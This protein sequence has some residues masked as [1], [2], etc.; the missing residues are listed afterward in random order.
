MHESLPTLDNS[1]REMDSEAGFGALETSKGPLPLKALNVKAHILGLVTRVLV[2]QT[3]VNT[4]R[5]A[6]EAVYIFPLPPRAAVSGFTMRVGDRLVEGMLFERGQAR[7]NYRRAIEAGKQAAMAEEDRPNVFTLSVGNLMPGDVAEICF[8]LSG[9]LS[10][11]GCEAEWRFPLVVAPRYIPGSPLEADPAGLGNSLDTDQ[12][13]DASRL[14]PPTLLP[15]YPNPVRLGI[16]IEFDP[17]GLAVSDIRSSLHAITERREGGRTLI[18]L[19][20]AE[21]VDRDFIL[22]C[23]LGSSQCQTTAVLVPDV[24]DSPSN[25]EYGIGTLMVTIVPPLPTQLERKGRDVVF[26]L[27]R[28][29]SMDGWKIVAARR[30]IARMV[31]TLGPDDRFEVITFS[32]VLDSLGKG[33]AGLLPATDL[34][35]FRALE[36]LAGT[37][38]VGG[39]EMAE[40]FRRALDLLRKTEPE[41]ES[42]LFLVTDG[43]VGNESGLLRLGND[44]GGACRF[45]IIGID[46]AINE[47]ILKR[48]AS[49]S[50]GWFLPAENEARLDKVLLAAS[51]MLGSPMITD[52]K[53]RGEGLGW[54]KKSLASSGSSDLYADTPLILMGRYGTSPEPAVIKIKGVLENG[55]EF[56]ETVPALTSQEASLRNIWARWK[57]RDM[58]DLL[59]S[60]K[61]RNL[62]TEIVEMSLTQGV[63]C[64][65]TA[66]LAVD[67]TPV[68]NPKGKPATIVQPVEKPRAWG[69]DYNFFSSDL[70]SA[71]C[72]IVQT[73]IARAVQGAPQAFLREMEDYECFCLGAAEPDPVNSATDFAAKLLRRLEEGEEIWMQPSSLADFHLLCRRLIELLGKA[74]FAGSPEA[75]G[76]GKLLLIVEKLTGAPSPEEGKSVQ[77][78]L[79]DLE[80]ALRAFLSR[81]CP[82]EEQTPRDPISPSPD[83]GARRFWEN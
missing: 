67:E 9:L 65:F 37:S 56:F 64:R 12:V 15:G 81:F 35:R 71:L 32:T 57:L 59:A 19:A 20:Q 33:L 13:P 75:E 52:I 5:E 45:Q 76:L 63:L 41:R 27:D 8:E 18:R 83:G 10:L 16:E 40:A 53:L 14:N 55:A 62:Q 70:E 69:D 48:L 54:I 23:N 22:R 49:A 43:Q 25:P 30:A 1:I 44:L 72:E 60:G 78:T 28:S 11:E 17:A 68:V 58:E 7:E 61:E 3:F 73:P 50:G 82:Q 46:E 34:N 42:I 4:H 77:E 51:R 38:A 24:P 31:D 47:S 79:Q 6:I 2:T 66:F 80:A 39:T 36:F 21:R 26:V 74:V 29:G